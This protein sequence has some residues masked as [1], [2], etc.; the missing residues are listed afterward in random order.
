VNAGERR[1]SLGL[2]QTLGDPWADVTEKFAAGSQVEG[3]VTSFTKFGAF[4][5]LAEGIEGM[6]H[7]SEISA[8]KRIERPQDV[9]RVGQVVKAKVLEVDKEKRQLRLSMKQLVPTGLDEYIAEH[10]V[11]EVVTGRLIEVA[12]EHGTVE[13]GEG[14]HAVGRL[15]LEVAAKE[16]P[17]GGALDLSSFSSMLAA[18]WKNGPSTNEAKAEAVRTGQI[19][20]FRI[21]MVDRG[22]KKIKVQLV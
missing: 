20:S 6:I 11:G 17:G 16:Q 19:R 14:I 4:V 18:R 21:T 13:L 1:M 12:G 8:E 5:Q 7:V 2:K 10:K 15:V 9:L 22:A 3:S